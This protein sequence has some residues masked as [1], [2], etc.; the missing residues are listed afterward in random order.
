MSGDMTV[1]MPSSERLQL[2]YKQC[3]IILMSHPS[4]DECK[5]G[6]SKSVREL[7]SDIR[8]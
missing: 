6:T 1:I 4:S 8:L 7:P 2:S 5:S 3:K